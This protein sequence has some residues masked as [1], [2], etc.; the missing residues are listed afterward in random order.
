MG[1]SYN[2]RGRNALTTVVIEAGRGTLAPVFK[3]AIAKTKLIVRIMAVPK[4][5]PWRVE[6]SLTCP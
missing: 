3:Y 2:S 6:G 5:T 4:L 1:S